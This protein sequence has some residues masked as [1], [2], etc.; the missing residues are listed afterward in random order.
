M[1]PLFLVGLVVLILGVLSFFVPIPQ[2]ENHGVKV[3]D[4]SIGVQTHHSEHIAPAI[5]GVLV[6]A[7]AVLMIAGGRRG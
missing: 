1:K 6:A 7:G 5:S 2:T 4:A 3:G